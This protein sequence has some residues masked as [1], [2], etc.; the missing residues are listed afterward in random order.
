MKQSFAGN[1]QLHRHCLCNATFNTLFT[2]QDRFQ[3][4]KSLWI[5]D[6]FGMINPLFNLSLSQ[7]NKSPGL[8]S[9]E[10]PPKFCF[11]LLEQIKKN[12]KVI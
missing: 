11:Y 8:C 9:A 4:T 2:R 3:S 5:D 12:Y 6:Q 7:A 10:F 1:D